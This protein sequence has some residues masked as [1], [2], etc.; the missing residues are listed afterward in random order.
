MSQRHQDKAGGGGPHGWRGPWGCRHDSCLWGQLTAPGAQC[1]GEQ[2]CRTGHRSAQRPAWPW[3]LTRRA[4]L[5]W[6]WPRAGGRGRSQISEDLVQAKEQGSYLQMQE[7]GVG[8]LQGSKERNTPRLRFHNRSLGEPAA[9]ACRRAAEAG[10]AGRPSSAS[11]LC[12]APSAWEMPNKCVLREQG[13]LSCGPGAHSGGGH[14][15]GKQG[16]LDQCCPRECS[17]GTHL[18]RV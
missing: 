4:P 14:V 2:S 18:S 7:V 17:G 10:A 6:R 5:D 13:R 15:G 8:F 11:A 1:P 3:Q 16:N 12:R 9:K